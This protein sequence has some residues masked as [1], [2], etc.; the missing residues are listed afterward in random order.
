MSSDGRTFPLPL[1]GFEREDGVSRREPSPI[2]SCWPSHL[3]N[4]INASDY[5]AGR[6]PRREINQFPR[7]VIRFVARNEVPR[8]ERKRER[9]GREKEFFVLAHKLLVGRRRTVLLFDPRTHGARRRR[10]ERKDEGGGEE[11]EAHSRRRVDPSRGL[12]RYVTARREREGEVGRRARKG[13]GSNFSLPGASSLRQTNCPSCGET[14]GSPPFDRGPV[15]RGPLFVESRVYA[16]RRRRYDR[17]TSGSMGWSTKKERRRTPRGR[18][19]FDEG[20]RGERSWSG[21]LLHFIDF[22]D[23]NFADLLGSLFIWFFVTSIANFTFL[24]SLSS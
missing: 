18:S 11:A 17:G 13:A 7:L 20:E 2:A 4:F 24:H 5:R 21:K 12:V 16:K 15:T 1:A 6:R 10:G 9:E 3:D 19:E 8:K 22:L 14:R 23:R